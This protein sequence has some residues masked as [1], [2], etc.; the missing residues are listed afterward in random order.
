VDI[1]V[2]SKLLGHK[3]LKTTEIYGKV[4]DLRREEAVMLL[5]SL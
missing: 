4:I 5:D 2:V 3:N 1:Y